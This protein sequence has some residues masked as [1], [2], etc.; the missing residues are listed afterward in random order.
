MS[1]Y[2]TDRWVEEGV[3]LYNIVFLGTF[4]VVPE[5]F[6]VEYADIHFA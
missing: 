2:I 3:K 6:I 5:S 1:G 4:K